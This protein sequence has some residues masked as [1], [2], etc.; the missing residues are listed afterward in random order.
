MAMG[1]SPRLS[2]GLPVYN[3]ER[4]LSEALDSVLGQTYEDFELIISDNAS[5]DDT[6]AICHR[7]EKQDSRIRYFRQPRNIGLSPNH[8]F[9]VEQ[10]RGEL[11]KWASYDDLY[12]RTLLE[13][14]IEALDEH[15]RHILAHSWTAMIN[16][17]D[18]VTKPYIYGLSTGSADVT[19]RFTSML[20]D[21]G[22]DDLYGVIRTSVLHQVLPH[23][24]Y[25]NSD[26]TLVARLALQG[27]FHQIPDWLY[28]RRDHP[29]QAERACPTT[30]SR[31]ANMDPRRADRLRNPTVR[32]YGE[33]IYAYL[34][35]I[36]RAPISRSDR[37]Q[38]YRIL[39]G[40]M[41]HRDKARGV[42]APTVASD[43]EL[44]IEA[45]VAGRERSVP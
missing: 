14:C 15:P 32:L 24:S 25:H 34:E 45:L 44:S 22:G 35:A 40:W 18:E 9:V 13:R 5:T 38:C 12:A 10:G 41:T 8:N 36:H 33:Y 16:S 3:G 6:E 7:Y 27:P 21:R 30:R 31:C 2:V 1:K 37:Q 29:E 11:F 17:D 43:V 4:F 19:E 23:D 26:R 20:Y 39:V 28:F 42:A